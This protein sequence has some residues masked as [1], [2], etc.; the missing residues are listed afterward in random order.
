VPA[1][2]RSGRRP[3]RVRRFVERVVLGIV[4]GLATWVLE[5]RLRKA[6]GKKG[7]RPSHGRT[8]EVS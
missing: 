2:G 1:R 3:G 7:R 8:I 6:L 4:F 5:R